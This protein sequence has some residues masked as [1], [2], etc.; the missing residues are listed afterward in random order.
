MLKTVKSTTL[1][2][3]SQIEVDGK[4]VTAVQMTANISG[5]ANTSENMTVVNKDLYEANIAECRSDMDAF[6]E[7][8]RA[9]EDNEN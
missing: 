3:Q 5:Q 8:Y 7:T 1:T 2:G 4:M 9:I 6:R